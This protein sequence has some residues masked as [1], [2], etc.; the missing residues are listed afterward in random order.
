ML[1]DVMLLLL[2]K[3]G[4]KS[5]PCQR[6]RVPGWITQACGIAQGPVDAQNWEGSLASRGRYAITREELGD[7]F[8]PAF[9]RLT[10]GN[11][12]DCI[13]WLMALLCTCMWYS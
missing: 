1:R 4:E 10:L 6:A 5:G 2:L 12:D 9:P 7:C 3:V 11:K 13:Y 8:E